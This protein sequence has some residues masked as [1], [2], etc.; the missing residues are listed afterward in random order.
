MLNAIIAAIKAHPEA[1]ITG[2]FAILASTIAGA[3]TLIVTSIF[4]QK[5]HRQTLQ[6]QIDM[7]LYD[8]K[9]EIYAKML[10]YL[11]K[12]DGCLTDL[13]V[14]YLFPPEQQS[15]KYALYRKKNIF[16][17]LRKYVELLNDEQGMEISSKFELYSSKRVNDLYMLLRVTYLRIDNEVSEKF[18]RSAKG[19]VDF[20]LLVEDEKLWGKI[21]SSSGS[22][23]QE[24]REISNELKVEMHNDLQISERDNF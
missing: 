9:E 16:E 7:K 24:V 22:M 6:S 21:T 5:R 11:A 14:E 1:I 13:S 18:V 8:K 20:A 19:G 15:N 2:T 4:A 23:Y 3:L 10:E 17:S 12:L